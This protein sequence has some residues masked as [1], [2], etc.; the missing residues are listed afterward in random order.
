M[1]S[2][3]AIWILAVLLVYLVVR[4]LMGRGTLG[5]AF[6]TV[7]TMNAVMADYRDGDY[8]SALQKAEL[9]KNGDQL[10][11]EYCFMTGSMLRHLGRLTEA[12]AILRKGLPLEEDPRQK[13]LV[14]NTLAD[15]LMDQ[16]RYPEALAFFENAGR[17]W[18]DRGANHRGMAEV[19]LRQGRE[20]AE[21]LEHARQAVEIDRQATGMKK[22][23]LNTRLGED[24][25]VL[26][27]AAAAN[28]SSREEVEANVAEAL[29]LCE[30]QNI[31]VLAEVHFHVAKAYAALKLP[32]QSREHLRQAREIDPNGTWGR[33]ANLASE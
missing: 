4:V 10:T 17:A 20:L 6:R 23:A 16:Q 2:T 7:R 21:A 24:L 13:G 29:R 26:A 33:L 3:L 14:Y 27:W 19:W 1:H 11:P 12:E 9:L 15:V 25:A 28:G 8:E 18:P 22:E 30:G 31:S 32:E 5:R